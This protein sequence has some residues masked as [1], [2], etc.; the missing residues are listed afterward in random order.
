[1]DWSKAGASGT[2]LAGAFSI[3]TDGGRD[4]GVATTLGG[5]LARADQG[6]GWKGNFSYGDAALWTQSAFDGA[7]ELVLDFGTTRL[8][9]AGAQIQANFFGVYQ[10][11]ITTYDIDGIAIETHVI[12]GVS[13]AA[14]GS[15][16]YLGVISE[17][18]FHRVGFQL[19]DAAYHRADYAINRVDVVI[20]MHMPVPPALWM[21]AGTLGLV[22]FRRYWSKRKSAKLH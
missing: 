20:A 16:V 11:R 1:M 6:N 7:N 3:A 14:R 8:F 4:V 9:A 13:S 2:S 12:S 21:G 10:A 18:A 19:D 17:S 15:A 5:D 22:A